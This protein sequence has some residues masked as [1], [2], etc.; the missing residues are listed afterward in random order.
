ME[1]L[2]VLLEF[3]GV[4]FFGGGGTLES[5]DS[6]SL[7]S[8]EHRPK[9]FLNNSSVFLSNMSFEAK[10]HDKVHLNFANILVSRT[11]SW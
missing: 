2:L 6:Q 4:I 5:K 8:H 1:T 7:S 3:I 10:S 11:N 9:D